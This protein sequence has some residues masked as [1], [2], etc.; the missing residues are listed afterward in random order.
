[1]H[2]VD[3]VAQVAKLCGVVLLLLPAAQP[4]VLECTP[5]KGR[6]RYWPCSDR[7]T[8]PQS[9]A[10]RELLRQQERVLVLVFGT[11]PQATVR[12]MIRF[13]RHP[14]RIQIIERQV[15]WRRGASKPATTNGG[16]NGR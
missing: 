9:C 4:P 14:E 12:W 7:S 5:G 11:P 3:V 1:M 2:L 15:G 6:S 8:G 16:D 13:H 10:S